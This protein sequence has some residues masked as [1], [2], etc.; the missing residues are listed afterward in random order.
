MASNGIP[1]SH[2]DLAGTAWSPACISKPAKCCEWRQMAY[3]TAIWIW[4][5]QLGV[6]PALANLQSVVNGVK[7]HT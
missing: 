2:L 1:D 3:L 5:E 4:L 6:P 7:W